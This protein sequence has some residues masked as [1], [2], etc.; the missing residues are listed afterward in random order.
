[1]P[2]KAENA[3]N[4]QDIEKGSI[5]PAGLDIS[6]AQGLET[7]LKIFTDAMT[8]LNAS[9]K[10]Q[11]T[12]VEAL[13]LHPDNPREE[14][15]IDTM[16]ASYRHRGYVTGAPVTVSKR[17]NGDLFV[18]RGNRRTAAAQWLQVN[19]PETFKRVFADGKIPCLILTGL[20]L[21]DE[22]ALLIDHGKEQDRRGLSKREELTAMRKLLMA[23]I[24]GRDAIARALD[25]VTR[26]KDDKTGKMVEKVRGPYVQPRLNLLSL[27]V[28]IQTAYLSSTMF[29]GE[30]AR[31]QQKHIAELYTAMGNDRKAGKIGAN[32]FGPELTAK[33]QEILA[34]VVEDRPSVDRYIAESKATALLQACKSR[35]AQRLVNVLAGFDQT[36][37]LA[38]VDTEITAIETSQVMLSQI[39]DVLGPVDFSDLCDRAEKHAKAKAADVAK[40]AA[41]AEKANSPVAAAG[42]EHTEVAEA[43]AVTV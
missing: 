25:L 9:G 31:M 8:G 5:V 6:T 38:D 37:K 16:V 36:S 21:A 27:P 10:T 19:E 35:S 40:A 34:T 33:W 15:D 39:A 4:P 12:P 2:V 7:E 11:K 43:E 14:L 41:D 18:L 20:T 42:V 22:I 17:A 1:M 24:R 30:D 29:G 32:G 3:A 23:G 26:T 13:K 28:D